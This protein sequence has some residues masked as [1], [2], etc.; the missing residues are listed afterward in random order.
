MR[1][2]LSLTILLLC[3]VAVQ[4][5]TI[6]SFVSD[7][8]LGT[9][10]SFTVTET[11]EYD[12]E[13]AVRHGIFR[14]IPTVHPQEA[15]AWYKK[16][17]IEIDVQNV[18]LD[19][20]DVPYEESSGGGEMHLKIGNPDLTITGEHVYTI[21]YYVRGALS[22]YAD[23]TAE[24]YWNVTGNGWEVPITSATAYIHGPSDLF[25]SS[26]TC[27]TG[28]VGADA[29]CEMQKT[30]DGLEF[31][32]ANLAPYEGLTIAAMLTHEQI[33][34]LVIERLSPAL[35]W[36]AAI[37]LWLIG[38]GIY[39]Y[40]YSTKHKTGNT[41]IAQYEPYEDLKPMYTGLLF[42][43]RIDASDITAG[44]VYLAEQGFFKIT[45]TKKKALFFFEVD[46]YEI[47]L[48][49][50]YTEL[51]SDFQKEIFTLLFSESAAV[52]DTIALS[53]L[54][55]DTTQQEENR[56]TLERLRKAADADLVAQGYFEKPTQQLMRMACWVVLLPAL[57][58]LIF[59]FL[60][61]ASFAVLI[62]AALA[63]AV[64]SGVMVL[65]VH[66]RRTRKGYEA[67]EYLKG[68]KQFLSVTEKER[69]AF[70]NAPAKSPEQFMEY[71]PYAIAFG[72]EK[73]WGAVFKDIS[74]PNP[75]WYES[76]NAA[77]FSAV[78]LSNSLGAFSTT[79]AS[80]SGSS[81]A[82]SG[83]GSSGGGA[84]GGGGGSW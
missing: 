74:I 47:T 52:S 7:I 42:D 83:G 80:A 53:E 77:A 31:Y 65:V 22:Y 5:E 19:G 27:Y 43:G 9:D 8:Q 17:Y 60:F 32:I 26:V 64:V 35:F 58:L 3:P 50:P 10:G 11:I 46:D 18:E 28:V 79:L 1:W 70:H 2:I 13:N 82:S 16:R 40:R 75:E 51:K 34:T 67:L 61:L 25:S 49:R 24:L 45:A 29:S 84:G 33:D 15:S 36:I 4:A 6:N 48:R 71:L 69:Y 39:L 78:H 59:G 23:D 73:E 57:V 44:I 62:P 41:I 68:F 63:M 21:T 12:F 55:K 81:P 66:R 20:G 56:K 37:A 38:L 76:N 30:D 54:A 14:Y 72:V